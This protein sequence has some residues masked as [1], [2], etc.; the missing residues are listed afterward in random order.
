MGDSYLVVFLEMSVEGEQIFVSCDCFLQLIK[1]SIIFLPN[2]SEKIFY[3]YKL[4]EKKE[5]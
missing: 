5:N 2:I 3:K 1:S 4:K